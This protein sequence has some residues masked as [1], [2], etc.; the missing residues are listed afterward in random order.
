VYHAKATPPA[1]LP[2]LSVV[3][4]PQASAVAKEPQLPALVVPRW[5]AVVE[6]NAGGTAAVALSKERSSLVTRV[7]ELVREGKQK[8]PHS[9]QLLADLASLSRLAPGHSV[10]TALSAAAEKVRQ[11]Q[12]VLR[13][14][15]DKLH[16]RQIQTVGRVMQTDG[17]S[18]LLE[19]WSLKG[20]ALL[21]DIA[22][23]GRSN[24]P[25]CHASLSDTAAAVASALPHAAALEA[26]IRRAEVLAETAAVQHDDAAAVTRLKGAAA[27]VAHESAMR[28]DEA[29][30]EAAVALFVSSALRFVSSSQRLAADM[31]LATTKVSAMAASAAAQPAPLAE[32]PVFAPSSKHGAASHA[33]VRPGDPTVPA[34]L[35]VGQG[36]LKRLRDT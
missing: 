4:A 29:L 28:A 35:V 14:A 34:A 30:A 9:A 33:E 32:A 25:L 15:V 31:Q 19:Q 12:T 23:L 22:Q 10:I 11:G 24:H 2:D 17:S 18:A 8:L 36:L 26:A 16:K 21:E 7:Q 3:A 20:D 1:E 13:A 5:E 27:Q 6:A